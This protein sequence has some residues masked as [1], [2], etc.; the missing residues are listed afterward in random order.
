MT[1]VAVFTPLPPSPSGIAQYSAE[2]LPLLARDLHLDVYIT[3]DA[4]A[5][6]PTPTWATIRRAREFPARQ[7]AYTAVIYQLGNNPAHAYIL[8]HLAPPT[9]PQPKSYQPPSSAPGICILHDVTLQ[10]LHRWR[11]ARD[12]PAGFRAYREEMARRYGTT[13]AAAADAF[14]ANR[15]A[16]A[17]GVDFPLCEHAIERSRAVI[18]HSRYARD[19]LLAHCPDAPVTVVPHGVPL[20]PHG[21]RAAARAA[22]GLPGGAFVVAAVGNLIPEKRLEVALRAFARAL[23]R[24]PAGLDAL[25]VIAGAASE[26]YSPAEFVRLHGLDPVVRQ[27]GA[28]D[29]ATFEALLV[30][31]DACVNLRWPTGGETSGSLLRALAAGRPTL[32]TDA[33]SFAEV[34]DDACLKVPLGPDEEDT[35]TDYLLRLAREPAWAA[36]VGTQARDF[37]TREHTLERAAEGYLAVMAKVCHAWATA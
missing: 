25:F 37:I 5:P 16:P 22:L 18:V 33:G 21:E 8:D 4:P 11:A 13:G 32:V 20:L 14:A 23:F 1:R 19:Q 26:H 36:A 24:L 6:D 27:L 17:T 12:G 2:L 31:A 3:D 10:H 34:P 35:V 15:D 9:Q 29:A 7:A 28:V 30:A